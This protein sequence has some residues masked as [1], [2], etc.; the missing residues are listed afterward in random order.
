MK[1]I[2]TEE[3]LFTLKGLNGVKKYLEEYLSQF[4]HFVKLEVRVSESSTGY[5]DTVENPTLIY[6]E[7]FVDEDLY[8]T[9]IDI[10]DE[11]QFAMDMYFPRGEDELI[12]VMWDYYF[13]WV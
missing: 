3:Q 4:E 8:E 12:S 9:D 5:F 2:I 11:I 6:F 1:I 13:E 7:I 10:D